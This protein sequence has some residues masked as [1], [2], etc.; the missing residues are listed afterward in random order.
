MK[1]Y[2]LLV[3]FLEYDGSKYPDSFKKFKSLIDPVSHIGKQYVVVD[4]Y[5]EGDWEEQVEDNL[6]RI[7]GNNADHE[8]SGWQKGMEYIKKNQI[9]YDVLLVCNDAFMA[10]GWTLLEKGDI[11]SMVRYAAEK[12]AV[13][14]QIDTKGKNFTCDN[15][16]V[17]S[18]ICTNCFFLSRK[19][20]QSIDNLVY[21]DEEKLDTIVGRQF[22]PDY[23]LDNNILNKAFREEIIKW[24]TVDWHSKFEIDDKTWGK[25]RAKAKAMLN[26]VSLTAEIRE[27][28]YEVKQYSEINNMNMANKGM[29]DKIF[30]YFFPSKPVKEK[31]CNDIFCKF[32]PH[33][34]F[35]SPIPDL[36]W[37][38][39]KEEKIYQMPKDIKG[40]DLNIDQQLKL[41]DQFQGFYDEMPFGDN[42]QDG[43][44][45]YFCNPAFSYPD[46]IVLYA[47]MRY[48]QPKKIIES[49]S[50]FSSGVMMDTN[51]KFFDDSIKC[52]LIEP[53][54]EVLEQVL[55]EGD[56]KK[57]NLI[58]KD[59]Q[60]VDSQVFDQLGD[61]DI[62]FVDSTHVSKIGSDV[63]KIIFEILPRLNSGVYIHFHDI[64]YPFEYPINWIQEGRA[65]NEVYI[66]RA[67]LQ[68]NRDFEIVFF[69]DYLGQFYQKELYQKMPRFLKNRG[70]SI[71]LKKIS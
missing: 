63:N 59:L 71:W 58:K 38:K 48:L 8:F 18:W 25:F 44:R 36:D 33:G 56:E 5:R 15:I 45:Y 43:L 69:N 31:G 52:T 29:V 7:G 57:I 17:S 35:Y 30:E 6:I 2:K 55:F 62:L 23:F 41:V 49:G 21:I 28:G 20:A 14:G 27:K 46:G 4:N 34:H 47:M 13:V 24:L 42:K 22:T 65:W 67:F 61:G 60:E 68:Y 1:E 26:E 37:L 9:D 10:Y 50:G 70:G 16:D 11:Y 53:F 12:K 64:F 40:I 19:I 32:A 54:T 39:K 3:L 66:L 51:Q